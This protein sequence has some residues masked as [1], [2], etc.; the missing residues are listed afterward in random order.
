VSPRARRPA[1]RLAARKSDHGEESAMSKPQFLMAGIAFGEQTEDYL[2]ANE[3]ANPLVVL[4]EGVQ[5]AF[6]TLVV[7]A[8]IGL[9]LALLLLGPRA[10]GSSSRRSRFPPR[11]TNE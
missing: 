5:Y 9:T 10:A 6:L 3:G 8:G 11:T 2:E 4:N 7:L 1:S